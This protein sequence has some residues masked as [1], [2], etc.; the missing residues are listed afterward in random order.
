MNNYLVREEHIPQR[1]RFPVV[2]AHNHLWE[3]WDTITETVAVMDRAGVLS[4]ADLTANASVV[5]ADGGCRIVKGDFERFCRQ[6]AERFPGRFYGFTAA[7]LIP[8]PMN[9]PLFKDVTRFVADTVDVMR[10]DI[11]RGARGLKVLKELGLLYRDGAGELVRAD[12]YRLAPIWEE[13]GRLGVPVL[14]HQSDPTG[15]F[16]PVTPENEHYDTMLKYP[17]WSFAD[18]SRFPSKRELLDRRD[19][20]I[21]AHPDTTFIL[22]HVANWPENLGYVGRL[23]DR[24]PNVVI[25]ISARLDELGRQPYTARAFMMHYA[26]RILFGTDMPVSERMYDC[27]FR[28]LETWDEAFAPPDYD[29]TFERYRWLIHGIGLPD[30]VLRKIYTQNALRIIPGLAEDLHGRL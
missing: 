8:P 7:T 26:D 19:R 21:A 30:A 13:A 10:E 4:Y 27:Y 17:A 14:I 29:G 15:F 20:L 1:A 12:D 9:G 24:N 23:L 22:P 6:V 25:D 18:R 3:Q 5:W 2:D 28:F 16:E 11:R